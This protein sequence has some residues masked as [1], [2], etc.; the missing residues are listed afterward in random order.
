MDEFDDDYLDGVGEYD[1]LSDDDDDGIRA[2]DVGAA[3]GLAHLMGKFKGTRGNPRALVQHL[4]AARVNPQRLV[5]KGVLGAPQAALLA[6]LS[7]VAKA[8]TVQMGSLDADYLR[9]P[10]IVCGVYGTTLAPGGTVAFSITPS[11]GTAWYRVLGFLAGFDQAQIM[12]FTALNVGGLNQLIGAQTTPTAP[13]TNAVGWMGFVSTGDRQ[14]FNL[15][16]WT[17]QT[18]DNSVA[19]TGTIV[20]MSVAA[21]GDAITL[22]PRFLIPAQVDPC[23]QSSAALA[24]AQKFNSSILRRALQIHRR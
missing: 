11:G 12:G 3:E 21:T 10:N 5:A 1:D 23:G 7:R 16:P 15:Q 2:I 19:I 8:I 18:F 20:N 22:N 4:A 13:V 6:H 14:V 17:G 9:R 24:S